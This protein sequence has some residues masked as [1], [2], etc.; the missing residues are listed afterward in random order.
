MNKLAVIRVRGI[1]K[2]N[3]DVEATLRMMRL[4]KK[5]YCVIVPSSEI[6]LGMLKKVKDFVTWGEISQEVIKGLIEKRGRLP[7]N[8]QIDESYLK[9]KLNLDYNGFAKQLFEGKKSLK[10]VPGLKEF[11]RLKPPVKGFERGG[12][13]KPFS[14]GGVLGYR[15]D[16]I[17]DLINRML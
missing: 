13:K 7:A 11:F 5:N 6:Y 2:V 9:E 1:V 16:K 3:R 15:K 8:K 17:N 14:L 12:V 10:D 4:Y